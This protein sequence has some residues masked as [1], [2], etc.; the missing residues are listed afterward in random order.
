M[1]IDI[2][3]QNKKLVAQLREALYNYTD[4]GVQ[5]ALDQTFHTQAKVFL[6][7]PFEQLDGAHGLYAKA[8]KPLYKAIP[9]LERR[10]TIVMAG[11]TDK[12]CHWVGCCG[13]YTGTFVY[14][15]LDIP[16]SG[17]HVAMRFHEF[18][19]IENNKIVE[20]QA[21]WD[22]PEVM[23]QAN[24]WPMTPSL[25]REW[26]VPGPAPQNGFVP[27]P[28]DSQRSAASLKIV[29]DMVIDLGKYATGGV[30]A[31]CLADHWHPSFSWYGPAGIGSCRGITGFRNRHQIP[32]LNAM[33]NRTNLLNNGHLFA[34]GDFVGFTAWPG[35]Q[36]EVS[37]D[38]WLGIAPSGKKITMRSL[39][40]WRCESGVIRENWVLVDLLDIYNQ[41]GVDVFSRLRDLSKPGW[42]E[43]ANETNQA[44]QST[45]MASSFSKGLIN[46]KQIGHL[47]KGTTLLQLGKRATITA[48]ARDKAQ[49][50]G[51]KIERVA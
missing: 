30:E 33:P 27:S 9:D 39:D 43:T 3:T 34:D 1:T 12:N 40:F 18:F 42:T 48:L 25:G 36:A 7:Y 29:L 16:P 28:F 47:P 15:W 37:E 20:M 5:T 17:H 45:A 24:A 22:I 32:F 31:M 35:M 50:M 6:S 41:L 49:Q 23:M 4:D 8:F 51:I 2:H 19:R 26:Q 13:Y 46:E 21:I 44:N 10:D 11:T 14:P 38:G